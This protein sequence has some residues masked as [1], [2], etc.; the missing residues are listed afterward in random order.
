MPWSTKLSRPLI[1]E[2]GTE[3]VTFKDAVEALINS[4]ARTLE[5]AALQYAIDLL[6]RAEKSKKA[7]DIETATDHIELVMRGRRLME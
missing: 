3:L 6:V 2:D 7:A 1:V 4:F 5:P